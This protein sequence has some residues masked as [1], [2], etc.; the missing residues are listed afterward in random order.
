MSK[1]TEELRQAWRQF[2]CAEA[3]MV[4][5]PFGPDRIRVAPPTS[6]A[7][8]ALAAVMLHHGYHIRTEDTDSYNCRA[9]TGGSGRSLHSFGIALDVNWQTNPFIDHEG[10]RTVRFSSK[11]TQDERALD[12]RFHLADTD[13][14]PEMI[15]DVNAIKTIDGVQV[16]EWGGSWRT[17][18]D[19]MHFELDLSP[20]ELAPGIDHSTVKGW[21]ESI[22]PPAAVSTSGDAPTATA[23]TLDPHIVIARDGLRLRSGPSAT[24][25]IKRT[26]PEGTRVNV[27][28][29]EGQWAQVDLEG[30]GRADGFMF[31]S[32]LKPVTDA[33]QVRPVVVS[34]V[35][36][37]PV[38]ADMLGF[39]TS[40]AVSKMFPFTPKANIVANLP[41]VVAGLRARLLTDRPMALVS[42]AT[43]RAET[44]G[45]VP[46]PEGV[47]RFNTANTP[48]DRY[49]G[50]TDLGN[51]QAG[52]GP[53]FKGR[54]YVQL[55]GRS[56]YARIGLQI[57][58]D[59]VGNPELAND[60]SIAGL[61][62]AQF[63]KNHETALRQALAVRDLRQARKLVNGG[64][65]GLD[66][67]TDAF[68]RGERAMPT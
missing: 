42:L 66:R 67:F 1:T 65:H 29:R 53:R 21:T 7:W 3:L 10:E 18:K 68:E 60:P 31:L 54:G 46:I 63:L 27:L 17:R 58:S 61:I 5:I 36:T 51:T 62:L 57:G 45:F 23:M 19:C 44:E 50:R 39:C 43:I 33:A 38:I 8:D 49:E 56:N 52:D 12:V 64:S 2:E 6:E 37:V 9:I 14:T 47:S 32:L 25:E 59:L 20:E 4:V 48:F 22:V 13:M 35:A 28:A 30:D 41:F 11:A 55:T 15:A 26:I 16:F 34:E 40:D 24:A